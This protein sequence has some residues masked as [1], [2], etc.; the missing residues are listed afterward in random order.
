MRFSDTSIPENF[1][2]DDSEHVADAT[3][4]IKKILGAKYV[5]ADLD[6]VVLECEHLNDT[7]RQLLLT[8]LK[9]YEDLF[10]G[11]LG[12]WH[13]EEYGLELKPGAQPYQARAFLV[14]K[15]YEATLRLEVDCLCQSLVLKKV[16]HL[17]WGAPTFIIPKKD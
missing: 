7:E 13:G 3:E 5:I 11:T 9:E 1:A 14:P 8:L 15:A 10:N 17:E 4:C 6:K 2:I 16:N 12:K